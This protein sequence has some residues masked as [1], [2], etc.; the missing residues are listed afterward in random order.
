[1]VR[2][3]SHG[4]PNICTSV[5]MKD[6]KS[7][8]MKTTIFIKGEEIFKKRVEQRPPPHNM[9]VVDSLKNVEDYTKFF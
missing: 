2:K 5:S 3:F 9:L 1:M 8:Y 4:I 7:F 6:I